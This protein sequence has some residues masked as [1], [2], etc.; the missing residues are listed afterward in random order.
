MHSSGKFT[1]LG[2]VLPVA[3]VRIPSV[4]T[5]A[6]PPHSICGAASYIPR[7]TE[8]E[9]RSNSP[10]TIRLANND[11]VLEM[12]K[13]HIASWRETYPGMLPDPMLARLSIANE[14][15]R[16][17]RMLDRPLAWGG[18]IAFVAEKQGIIVGYG[19]CG[20]QRTELLRDHGFT[21][22]IGELYILRNAQRQGAGSRLIKCMAA[23]L[24][25]REHRA[26]SLWV[27][28]ENGPARRFYE[29][30]GGALIARKHRGLAEVAYGWSD[31]RQLAART[32]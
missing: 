11:D 21:A 32:G 29:R 25:Q 19:S 1:P 5:L 26:M 8:P 12:A 7:V 20:G 3:I 16:W 30:L 23:A 31:L 4:R 18:S 6:S 14:A 22:E 10:P 17:Q 9:K 2:C 27:L 24:L 13:V 15:I 28:E